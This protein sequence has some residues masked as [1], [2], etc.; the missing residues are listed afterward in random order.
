MTNNFST[1]IR[2]PLLKTIKSPIE[3]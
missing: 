1:K 3:D 2:I